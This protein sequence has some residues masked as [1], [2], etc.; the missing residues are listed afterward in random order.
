MYPKYIRKVWYFP[1]FF[2]IY[3][4]DKQFKKVIKMIKCLSCIMLI[5]MYILPGFSSVR[6]LPEV[7]IPGDDD[8]IIIYPPKKVVDNEKS[9]DLNILKVQMDLKI[10]DKK[11]FPCY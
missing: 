6:V 3:L 11:I 8:P 1:D 7:I 2:S 5:S 4:Q 10:Q 9:T